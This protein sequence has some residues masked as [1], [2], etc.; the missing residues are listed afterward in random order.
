MSA[1]GE[2]LRQHAS[3]FDQAGSTPG[4]WKARAMRKL[5]IM[6]RNGRGVLLNTSSAKN[7]SST[8]HVG[9]HPS[10]SAQTSENEIMSN[11][12]SPEH[13][14]LKRLAL[15]W[16]QAQGFRVAAAEVYILP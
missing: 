11:L 8:S 16:A 14:E 9:A 6:E 3:K 15:I 10:P 13:K 12:E 7:Q 1:G 5:A 4:L 2:F